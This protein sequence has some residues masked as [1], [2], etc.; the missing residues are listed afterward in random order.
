MSAWST[1]RRVVV[2]GGERGGG[3]GEREGVPPRWVTAAHW[4]GGMTAASRLR[5][6]DAGRAGQ[7]EDF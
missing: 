6:A 4:S 2:R 1:R 7:V 5:R 3:L